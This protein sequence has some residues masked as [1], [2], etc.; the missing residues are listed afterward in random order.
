MSEEFDFDTTLEQARNGD[1]IKQVALADAYSEGNGAP[2]D[3][4][5][6]LKWYNTAADLG[7][8]E[9][10]YHLGMMHLQG[11]G[12]EQDDATAYKWICSA[13]RQGES[14]AQ[15]ILGWMYYEGRGV[16]KDHSESLV[17][18]RL[19]AKHKHCDAYYGLGLLH[20]DGDDIECDDEEALRWFSLAAE[21][22]H[23]DAQNCLGFM[24]ATGR[25]R[26]P[27]N[28]IE[29]YRWYS[30]A[31]GQGHTGAQYIIG[32]MHLEGQGVPADV[33]LAEKWL[34][35]SA[36]RGEENAQ[37]LLGRLFLKGTIEGPHSATEIEWCRLA[38]DLDYEA[39]TT[40]PDSE[41]HEALERLHAMVGLAEVKSEIDNLVAVARTHILRT[42]IGLR[43]SPIS[44]HLVFIGNPGT[45]KTSVA[46]EVG[47]IYAALGF[48]EKGHVVEVQRQDLVGEFIGQ[49]AP[50]TSRKI[51]EALGGVLFIDEAY[52]LAPSD[53]L[54]DFGQEAISTLIAEMENNRH[55]LAVIVAGYADEM[56]RFLDLNPGMKSRFNRYLHFEDYTPEELCEMFYRLADQHDYTISPSTAKAIENRIRVEC[57]TKGRD[58]GNG[59]FVRNLFE[60]T[61]T[62]HAVRIQKLGL[63]DKKSLI[64]LDPG[65]I[66]MFPGRHKLGSEKAVSSI[67][68]E[69]G[70]PLSPSSDEENRR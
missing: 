9:A 66:P 63:K 5:E 38:E 58:F 44:L 51:S 69:G 34:R 68:G 49:T 17:W 14:R 50:T 35:M 36:D 60:S 22:G 11:R 10:Q 6:A 62:N 8:S 45:G 15:S 31:G 67:T 24:H 53:S 26:A 59:R 43:T 1:V 29:A 30:L 12:V 65:D 3:D 18:F 56:N 23:V 70:I 41:L 37:R 47:R 64:Q 32:V 28:D 27:P 57:R 16:Q 21:M 13:S 40:N 61:T 46:R 48:L 42:E 39:S 25:R 54:R 20:L 33:S 4:T 55:C 52:S 19:A 2:Q 7:N